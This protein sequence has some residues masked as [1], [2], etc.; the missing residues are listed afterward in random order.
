MAAPGAD[1]EHCQSVQGVVATQIGDQVSVQRFMASANVGAART[2]LAINL[3]LSS[4]LYISSI[5][6][7]L[8][9]LYRVDDAK[10]ELIGIHI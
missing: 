5:S 9:F 3:L 7:I 6:C 2:S 10:T 4:I 8:I 1:R